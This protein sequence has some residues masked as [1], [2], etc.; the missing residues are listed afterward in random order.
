MQEQLQE[1][2]LEN[3]RLQ[4]TVRR[5]EAALVH[6]DKM[7]S[8]KEILTRNLYAELESTMRERSDAVARV[9]VL[10]E[11][12]RIAREIHDIVGHTLTLTIVQMELGLR[13]LAESPLEARTKLETSQELVRQSLGELRR[14]VRRLK[15]GTLSKEFVPSLLGLIRQTEALSGVRV[16]A[17]VQDHCRTLGATGQNVIYHALREGLTNGIRHGKSSAFRFRLVAED[18]FVH[19]SLKDDGV[20][21]AEAKLG[22]GLGTLKERVALLGGSMHLFAQPGEGCHLILSIPAGGD[23]ETT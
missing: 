3:Q 6:S 19:F 11:R 2:K 8:S 18:G 4:R 23:G 17:D 13:L 10:E 14:S 21:F 12:N 7:S 1:L 16:T 20:G 15:E 9:A 22:F 5:L